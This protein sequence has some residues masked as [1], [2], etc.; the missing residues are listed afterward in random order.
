MS[1]NTTTKNYADG[2]PLFESDLDDL[3]QDLQ[4]SKSNLALSTTGST[5]GQLLQSTGSNAEPSWVSADTVAGNITSTG[6]NSIA[7][8][9]TASGANQIGLDMTSTAANSIVGALSSV[10]ASVSNLIY[11]AVSRASVSSSVGIRGIAL[12]DSSGTFASSSTSLTDITNLTVTI[13]TSGRPVQISLQPDG[14]GSQA[15]IGFTLG[16]AADGGCVDFNLVRTAGTVSTNVGVYRLA[17]RWNGSTAD[18]ALETIL[19]PF[20]DTGIAGSAG[21]Y[22]YKLQSQVQGIVFGGSL[23]GTTGI[24]QVY[25]QKMVAYEL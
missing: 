7:A 17:S 6:A 8:T 19:P 16:S 13:V 2:T 24:A 25:R 22:T 3:Y 20:V 10:V 9:M 14:S 18:G 5:S 11:D 15:G 4:V 1:D 23:S 12:S 21:T